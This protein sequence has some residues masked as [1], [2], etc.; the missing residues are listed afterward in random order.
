MVRGVIG[1]VMKASANALIPSEASTSPSTKE[2]VVASSPASNQEKTAEITTID[3]AKPG[4]LDKRFGQATGPRTELGK[5][6]SS[7]NARRHGIFSHAI[8]IKSE[9]R[10]EFDSL[11]LGLYEALEPQ[12]AL[13]ELLVDKLASLSWR[14][15]RL[16]LAE[17]GEIRSQFLKWS[18]ERDQKID[19]ASDALRKENRLVSE[20]QD[21][22]VLERCLKLLAELRD[23]IEENGFQ[24]KRDKSILE[25]LYGSNEYS[26]DRLVQDYALWVYTAQA[27][28]EERI[29]EGYATPEECKQNVLKSIAEEIRHV[30]A[31]H[32]KRINVESQE[33]EIELARRSVPESEL[34][35]RLL[36]YEASLERAFDRALSQLERIQRMRRGQQV[37]PRLDVTISGDIPK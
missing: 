13:E 18:Q 12:G 33:N 35:E 7:Q 3:L 22:K 16:L 24:E 6:R 14:Y 2:I 23:G 20:I 26:R 17:T 27:T 15:R 8:L 9:S 4:M 21:L 11:R 32:K 34:L 25:M 5:Q 37:A 10:Q 36:R 1:Q 19:D 31:K 29:R 30:K 28:E